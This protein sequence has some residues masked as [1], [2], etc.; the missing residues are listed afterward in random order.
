MPSYLVLQ[1][2]ILFPELVVL[3]LDPQVMLDLLLLIVMAALHLFILETLNLLL[4][5]SLLV[6]ECLKSQYYFFDVFLPLLDHLLHLA[7][8]R[9]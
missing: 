5:S 9:D 2:T 7:V 4:E 3:L 8:V 6:S 1:L